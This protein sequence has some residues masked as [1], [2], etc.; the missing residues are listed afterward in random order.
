MCF[1]LRQT[2]GIRS[3]ELLWWG[4]QLRGYLM[5]VGLLKL[6]AVVLTVLEMP[7]LSCMELL[8]GLRN[9]LVILA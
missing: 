9:R 3:W 1:L 8:G 5:M 6:I 2:M 4:V 7:V